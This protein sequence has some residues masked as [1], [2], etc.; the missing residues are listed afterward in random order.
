MGSLFGGGG[1]GYDTSAMAAA[2][3]EANA[4]Q[5]QIY[6]ENKE[7][8]KPWYTAGSASVTKLMDLLGLQ[9]GSVKTREQ[10]VQELTPQYSSNQSNPQA[11]SPRAWTD[12]Y[13]KP[14]SDADRTALETYRP[15]LLKLDTSKYGK[16]GT[17]ANVGQAKDIAK[18]FSGYTPTSTGSSVNYDALN[19]AV[20][21]RLASQGETPEGFGSMAK[22][23]SMDDYQE[24][25]GYQFRLQEGNKALERALAARGKTFTPEAIKAL[26]DYNG[27]SAAQEYGASYDRFNNDQNTLFGRYATLSGFGQQANAQNAAGGQ[28]YASGVGEN[29][30]NLANAQTSAA[31]AKASRPSMFSQLMN[32]GLQAGQ[33]YAAFSDER[34]KDIHREID[35]IDGVKR[36][37][38]NYKGETQRYS[39]AKAQQVMEVIPDAVFEAPDGMLMVDYSK[40]PFQ[41]E[42]I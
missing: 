20:D 17:S 28:A 8:S 25:P 36:Y 22:S 29:N 10:L 35:E 38:F 3:K 23:F 19:A 4:L 1:G 7:A 34:M 30:L 32:T 14:M 31:V 18:F 33:M 15:D 5:K 27:G 6:E 12:Y 2:T 39:G 42:A 26:T 21:E 11:A 41:M 37:E 16:Y 24:D 40:L 9:G 13:N